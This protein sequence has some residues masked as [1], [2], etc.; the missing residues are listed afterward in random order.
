M[1]DVDKLFIDV[2]GREE[3]GRPIDISQYEVNV[4]ITDD[5]STYLSDIVSLKASTMLF[6]R[7]ELINE[8]PFALIY[9]NTTE[10]PVDVHFKLTGAD[11]QNAIVI[12]KA[13]RY[14]QEMTSNSTITELEKLRSRVEKLER[15]EPE[16]AKALRHAGKITKS[17]DLAE[18]EREIKESQKADQKKS[19]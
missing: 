4:K 10:V 14:V 2:D 18:A 7:Y 13:K 17:E 19:A 5:E 16:T 3:N 12:N 15:E 1:H 11:A 9:K 6:G 8:S